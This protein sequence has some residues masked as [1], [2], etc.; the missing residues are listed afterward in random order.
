M[1]KIFSA[2]LI[3]QIGK[4]QNNDS[5]NFDEQI[6]EHKKEN[7]QLLKELDALIKAT[8]EEKQREAAAE[9]L[10]IE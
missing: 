2:F 9:K 3:F 4:K 10:L 5:D 8:L 7:V 6:A 1:K